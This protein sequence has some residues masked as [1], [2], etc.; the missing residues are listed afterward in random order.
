MVLSSS[1]S[2]LLCKK[3]DEYKTPFVHFRDTAVPLGREQKETIG[4]LCHSFFFPSTSESV[5]CSP[6]VPA[7]LPEVYSPSVL[8]SPT[9]T[10]LYLLPFPQRTEMACSC[11]SLLIS[12]SPIF[13]NVF[14]PARRFLLMTIISGLMNGSPLI[15][16]ND[17]Q[18][19]PSDPPLYLDS[20]LPPSRFPRPLPPPL[21]KL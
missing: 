20:S 17:F 2:P 19:F 15:K 3:C 11:F 16:V 14:M 6:T 8:F 1:C 4:F 21:I 7:F 9:L 10:I 13:G 18:L 5:I 12:F